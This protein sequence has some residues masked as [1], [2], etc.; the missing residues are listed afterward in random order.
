MTLCR[1][2]SRGRPLH[3]ARGA[4]PRDP[5]SVSTRRQSEE[6]PHNSG[7]PPSPLRS[8]S[9]ADYRDFV[10]PKSV[11]RENFRARHSRHRIKTT[12]VTFTRPDVS[13]NK[14]TRPSSATRP[15][16]RHP[17]PNTAHD[18][19]P[20]QSHARKAGRTANAPRRTTGTRTRPA[21]H[22]NAKAHAH[23]AASTLLEQRPRA[24]EP[25]RSQAWRP[26]AQQKTKKGDS[27]DLGDLADTEFHKSGFTVS[28]AAPHG[29]FLARLAH[30]DRAGAKGAGRPQESAQP[31]R[32]AFIFPAPR[33]RRR[34]RRASLRPYNV[35]VMQSAPPDPQGIQQT[36]GAAAPPGAVKQRRLLCITL[37]YRE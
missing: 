34:R 28:G 10:E 16:V 29:S 18:H 6:T 36:R 12:R 24:Q 2:A 26:A 11:S 33:R 7:G 19:Q 21:A 14:N 1:A 15:P 13:R 4:S 17:T 37:H 3:P 23:A 30:A 5:S 35:D 20:T 22:A 27:A 9:P 31:S 25:A 32:T 8:P